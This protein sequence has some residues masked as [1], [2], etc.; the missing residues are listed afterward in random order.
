MP[1]NIRVDF[2]GKDEMVFN[3]SENFTHIKT[4]PHFSVVQSLYGNY[5]IQINNGE[6]FITPN[7][8]MFVAPPQCTQTITHLLSNGEMKARWLFFNI[9]VD[10]HSAELLYDF[11]TIPSKEDTLT[12]NS[13]LD[14]L[15]SVEDICDTMSLCYQITK[16]LLSSA[17]KKNAPCNDVLLS[18]L[19]YIKENHSQKITISSLASFAHMS[20]SN[21]YASFKKQFG[22]S[23]ISYLNDYRLSVASKLL[24]TTNNSLEA[25]CQSV[26]IDD[27]R[28]FSKIFKRK[29]NFTPSAYRKNTLI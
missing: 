11:P 25:V 28:Y 10:S 8:G 29:F 19:N 24:K 2:V 3:H 22:S 14:S 17:I 9:E 18:V 23:P 7:G 26:G 27:V 13:L 1:S 21:L 16:I 5:G 6:S 20:E 15:F 12:L 4:L